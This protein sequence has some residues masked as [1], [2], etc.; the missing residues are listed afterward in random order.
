MK[1]Y[2]SRGAC[3]LAARI[4]VNE[5]GLPCEYE[6]VDL[7]TKKTE[8]GKDFFAIN[9]KGVVPTLETDDKH[10]LTE[11]AVIL[12]YLADTHPKPELFPPLGQFKRYQVLEWVNYVAT[13]LHKGVGVL[14]HSGIS[15]E[16]KESFYIPIIR[17]KFN[18]LNQQLFHHRYL[19]ENEFTLPDA[20]L[21]VILTWAIHFKFNLADW[22]ELERYFLE[23]KKRPA[24]IKSLQEEKLI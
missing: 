18:Y 15:Q 2:Y 21:F 12:Q 1:L 6:S 19:V 11:N 4:I 14:F 10:V 5:L 24:V 7:K 13:E 23:V 3:S 9:P 20:Y 22:P 17:N 16:M 8:T